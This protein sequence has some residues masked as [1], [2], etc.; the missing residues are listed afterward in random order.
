M[1]DKVKGNEIPTKLIVP[2]LIIIIIIL[3]VTNTLDLR[4]DTDPVEDDDDYEDTESVNIVNW[5]LGHSSLSLLK[6]WAVDM[7][8]PPT[9]ADQLWFSGIPKGKKDPS[10]QVTLGIWWWLSLARFL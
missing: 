2:L 5:G 7:G 9:P 8:D 3:I 6:W 10:G 4:G 1:I